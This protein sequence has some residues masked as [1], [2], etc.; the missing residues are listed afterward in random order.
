VLLT[1]H[2]R[3]INGLTGHSINPNPIYSCRV[4]VGFAGRVKIAKPSSV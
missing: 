4:R 3:V 1:G 2:K